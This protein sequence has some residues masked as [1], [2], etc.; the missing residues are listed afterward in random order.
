MEDRF[1]ASRVYSLG[2][3]LWGVGTLGLDIFRI[4]GSFWASR[5]FR[6]LEAFKA[7]TC[8]CIGLGFKAFCCMLLVH[9]G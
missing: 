6:M 4:R 2:C 3:R 7:N 9:H 5:G 8:C 1:R